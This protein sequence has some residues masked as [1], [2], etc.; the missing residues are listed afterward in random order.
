MRAKQKPARS[1]CCDKENQTDLF[2]Q[3]DCEPGV[4]CSEFELRLHFILTK[5][6]FH[7]GPRLLE[8]LL[9]Q[10][11]AAKPQRVQIS[12]TTAWIAGLWAET[13][14]TPTGAAYCVKKNPD[15]RGLLANEHRSALAKPANS[16]EH[17]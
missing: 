5:P 6:L 1:D 14:K 11:A 10:R 8:H 12:M 17:H 7:R 15:C 3:S 13:S 4:Q 2:V 9:K 16:S